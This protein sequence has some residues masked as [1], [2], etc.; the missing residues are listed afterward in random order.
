MGKMFGKMGNWACQE[1]SIPSMVVNIRV[2]NRWTCCQQQSP[3]PKLGDVAVINNFG[4][5][6]MWPRTIW[7][8]SKQINF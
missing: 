7:R 8:K 4:G 2:E 1:N 6:W 3:T 5:S